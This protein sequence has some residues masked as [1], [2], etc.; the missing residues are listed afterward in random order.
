MGYLKSKNI[1]FTAQGAVRHIDFS[2][3]EQHGK[4]K[5]KKTLAKIL[6]C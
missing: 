4:K 6:N 2:P 5:G 3:M 1:E